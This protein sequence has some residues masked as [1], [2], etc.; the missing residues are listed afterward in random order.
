[1]YGV[2]LCDGYNQ[3]FIIS[4]LSGSRGGNGNYELFIIQEC[5]II[6]QGGG[7]V[8]Y[9]QYIEDTSVCCN[10]ILQAAIWVGLVSACYH[11]G[12][13][14]CS[15]LQQIWIQVPGSGQPGKQRGQSDGYKE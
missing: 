7:E 2:I 10:Q 4:I 1:M 6:S 15:E 14:R 13:H 11:R 5:V 9:I 3:S 8:W 12:A